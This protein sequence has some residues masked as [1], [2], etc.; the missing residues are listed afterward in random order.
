MAKITE[1]HG[2][3][4]YVHIFDTAL[5]QKYAS[6]VVALSHL[7]VTRIRYFNTFGAVT[8]MDAFNEKGVLPYS[9]LGAYHAHRALINPVFQRHFSP[10][11]ET[12]C[13]TLSKHLQ[14]PCQLNDQIGF[15]GFHIYG[16]TQSE[17]QLDQEYIDAFVGDS[18]SHLHVDIQYLPHLPIWDQYAEVDLLNP[19]S[20]TLTLQLPES[21]SALRYWHSIESPE[22]AQAFNYLTVEQRALSLGNVNVAK[23]E[24]GVLTYF[25]GHLIHQ[26]PAAHPLQVT[27]RRITLQG[28]GIKCDGTWQLYF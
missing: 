22:A 3:V 9:E 8:Y 26:I 6:K 4:H 7:W 19:L 14:T 13:E 16:A 11:Y 12:L 21:G 24:P 2:T 27:D 5:A 1:T 15:P 20:F 10:L 23:Y 25:I 17:G 28:H 18:W